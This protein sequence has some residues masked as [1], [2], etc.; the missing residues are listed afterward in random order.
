ML[1]VE[2]YALN[3]FIECKLQLSNDLQTVD[4]LVD[5]QW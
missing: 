1:Y 3:L 4:N 2:Q 5:N